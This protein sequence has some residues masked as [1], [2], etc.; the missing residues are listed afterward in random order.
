MDRK[1]L[2]LLSNRYLFE[3]SFSTSCELYRKLYREIVSI[4]A[5]LTTECVPKMLVTL[6][7]KMQTS[8]IREG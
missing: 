1:I 5:S 6:F 8:F 2:M 3:N 4:V 7:R